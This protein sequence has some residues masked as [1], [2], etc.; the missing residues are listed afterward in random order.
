MRVSV[1]G[2]GY[3]GC[4]SAACLA[5]QGH[6]VVGVDVSQSKV[7]LVLRGVAPVVEERIGE[8]TADVVAAGKLTATTDSARAVA[9]TEISLVCVGTPSSP[10]GSLS[11]VYLERVAQ[12]LEMPTSRAPTIGIAVVAAGAAPS[13]H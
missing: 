12:A 5:Q 2:L 7:D 13:C 10:N 11:T 8:L 4:V 3:V 6:D 9:E 1:F